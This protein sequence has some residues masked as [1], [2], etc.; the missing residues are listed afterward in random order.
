MPMLDDA[1]WREIAPLLRG[2]DNPEICELALARYHE[3]TGLRETNINAIWH[4]RASL[5]GPPCSNCG[6]PLRTPKAKWCPACG[7]SAETPLKVCPEQAGLGDGHIGNNEPQFRKVTDP[8][9]PAAKKSSFDFDALYDG[10]GSFIG[11]IAG[12]ATFVA[13]WI[14]CVGEYGFLWGFGFGWVP[15]AMLAVVVGWV[16]RFIWGIGLILLVL[17]LISLIFG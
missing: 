4:H 15:S 13:S 7:A 3:L 1:E 11:V 16:T 17:G 2:S 8:Q 12:F 10:L 6:K 14:Y 5:F 9:P